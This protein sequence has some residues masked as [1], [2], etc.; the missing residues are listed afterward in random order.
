[1]YFLAEHGGSL[2]TIDGQ[3][4]TLLHLASRGN[5]RDSVKMILDNSK[6][7]DVNTRNAFG[8]KPIH[9]ASENGHNRVMKIM[10]N[11]GADIN[12]R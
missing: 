9:I 1:M 6:A 12:S 7:K 2:D 5:H 4:N 3:Q 8:Q 11:Y 10:I